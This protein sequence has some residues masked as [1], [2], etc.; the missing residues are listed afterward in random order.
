MGD[1]R[2]TYK[3]DQVLEEEVRV[4][5]PTDLRN[6]QATTNELVRDQSTPTTTVAVTKAVKDMMARNDRFRDLQDTS[7]Y[8]RLHEALISRFA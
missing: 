4:E 2:A 7:E 8:V 3:P 6:I 5:F 1:C